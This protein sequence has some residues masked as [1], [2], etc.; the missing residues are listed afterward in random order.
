MAERNQIKN[1][2]VAVIQITLEVTTLKEFPVPVDKT[3]LGA[4]H[5]SSDFPPTDLGPAA[6]T[7]ILN[8][9][10][11]SA[12]LIFTIAWDPAILP[13]KPSPEQNLH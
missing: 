12:I 5:L 11:P 2:T 8:A 3:N 10:R 6:E 1:L 13:D 9:G 7:P 4:F